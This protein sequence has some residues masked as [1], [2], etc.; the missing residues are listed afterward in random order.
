MPGVTCLL[1]ASSPSERAISR[2]RIDCFP[3]FAATAE[4][5]SP[6]RTV[7]V[8]M[9]DARDGGFRSPNDAGGRRSE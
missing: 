4:W 6:N 1:P 9:T 2:S 7:A 5:A 8:P 3:N